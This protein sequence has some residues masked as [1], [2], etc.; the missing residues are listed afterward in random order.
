MCADHIVDPAN[1]KKLR[2]RIS[3]AVFP[4]LD[5]EFEY[6]RA[7]TAFAP[8]D[9]SDA[10]CGYRLDH[11]IAAEIKTQHALIGYGIEHPPFLYQR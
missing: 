3:I 2:A 8:L 1:F 4:D 11:K 10:L 6:A 7:V 9:K 5:G